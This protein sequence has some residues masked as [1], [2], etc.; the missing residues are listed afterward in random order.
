MKKIILKL[1]ILTFLMMPHSNAGY[2]GEGPVK[3]EPY[4]VD[5]YINWLKGG[6]GKK[7]M[8]FY[9]TT[10]G[11]DGIG[12]YCAEHD[13]QSPSYSQDISICERET[14][15]ECK[16]FGRR[17][18]IVWKNGINPGKGKESK[19]NSKA[20]DFEIKQRLKELGFID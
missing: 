14:G 9:L 16:L 6:W 13:C 7:P 20:S 1:V 2:K 11:D 15:K 5:Y 12:W 18:Q 8:V 17:N 10:S 3:L 19:I 4:M